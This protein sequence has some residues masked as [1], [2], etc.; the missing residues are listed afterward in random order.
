MQNMLMGL[1]VVSYIQEETLTLKILK[2]FQMISS[3]IS[4]SNMEHT[5]ALNLSLIMTLT[6]MKILS[7]MRIKIKMETAH[8]EITEV[9]NKLYQTL[10]SY[11]TTDIGK[12]RLHSHPNQKIHTLSVVSISASY[13][14]VSFNQS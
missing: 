3:L 7:L 9:M 12:E 10:V 6:M 2:I 13:A 4:Y 5:K 14:K 1:S 11:G 8:I